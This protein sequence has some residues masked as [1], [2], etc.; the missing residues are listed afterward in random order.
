MGIII[1]FLAL[2]P[3]TWVPSVKIGG[4]MLNYVEFG[5]IGLFIKQIGF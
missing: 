2:F 5:G 1:H 4:I 3:P